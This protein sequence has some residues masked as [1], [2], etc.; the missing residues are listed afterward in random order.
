MIANFKA[1]WQV[2]TFGTDEEYAEVV[3]DDETAAEELI[4]D[5]EPQLLEHGR[6]I[7]ATQEAP[8]AKASFNMK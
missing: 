2:A 7:W 6:R 4:Q 3:K 5:F 8:L 1:I